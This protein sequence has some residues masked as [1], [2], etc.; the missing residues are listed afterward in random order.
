MVFF[1]EGGGRVHI[2]QTTLI[3]DFVCHFVFFLVFFFNSLGFLTSCVSGTCLALFELCEA[4]PDIIS[5]LNVWFI[6]RMRKEC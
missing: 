4:D 1:G 2:R 5:L 3:H 6:L